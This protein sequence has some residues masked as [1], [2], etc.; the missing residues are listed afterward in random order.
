MEAQARPSSR[1]SPQGWWPLLPE[2]LERGYLP[3]FTLTGH[4]STCSTLPNLS[5]A[6]HNVAVIRVPVLTMSPLLRLS[7]TA[8]RQFSVSVSP[9]F[10][11]SASTVK[12]LSAH[13]CQEIQGVEL[14][15]E[16]SYA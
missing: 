6:A 11:R 15:V 4:Y 16:F 10:R 1:F 13:F 12:P 7:V 2:E 14:D 9:H 8:L 5:L 3:L